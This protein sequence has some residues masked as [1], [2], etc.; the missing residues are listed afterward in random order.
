[1][2]NQPPEW[3]VD[4]LHVALPH[5]ANRAQ[6]VQDVNTTPVDELPHVLGG[7]ARAVEQLQAARP[8]IE[9]ARAHFK[10]HGELPPQYADAADL[11]G[12][13]A[14]DAGHRRGAA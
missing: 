10:E 14:R 7:W 1:M 13:I 5:S 8:Q 2:T 3:N 11:T 12:D 9:A 6:L 4:R